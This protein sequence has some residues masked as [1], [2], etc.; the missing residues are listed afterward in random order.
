MVRMS[1]DELYMTMAALI[2]RRTT[3]IRGQNSGA[4]VV[5]DNR[6][7]SM[8]YAGSPPGM[9]H[10]TDVGC[11]MVNGGCVATLH[12]EANAIGWA[13]RTGIALSGGTIYTLLAPCLS[14]AKLI[15]ISGIVEVVY[16]NKYR[17][18]EGLDYLL[19]AMPT[20]NVRQIIVSNCV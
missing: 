12:S 15:I 3:C 5:V 7:V 18:K 2:S 11:T 13:A 10:C 16:M 19:G 9:P 14:C 17:K 20:I 6:V 1:R 4:V 8:G